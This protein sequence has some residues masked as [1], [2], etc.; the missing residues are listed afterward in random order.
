[1][2]EDKRRASDMAK[3][4]YAKDSQSI[5]VRSLYAYTLF[6]SGDG[7]TAEEMIR[8]LHEY[9]QIAAYTYAM[10]Q[11]N[12]SDTAAALQ[13]LRRIITMEPGSFVAQAANNKLI[14]RGAEYI[15]ENDPQVLKQLLNSQFVVSV[16]PEFNKPQDTVTTK[17]SLSGVEFGYGS[18][19]GMHVIIGNNGKQPLVITDTSFFQGEIYIRVNITGDIEGIRPIEIRKRVTPVAPIQPGG[20]LAIPIQL[21]VEAATLGKILRDF[22]QANLNLSF[23]AYFDPQLDAEGRITS[24]IPIATT[25]ARRLGVILTNELLDKRIESLRSGQAGQKMQ[26][27]KLINGL[28]AE[29]SAAEKYGV[30]Y[31]HKAI[32][33]DSIERAFALALNDDNWQIKLYILDVL[34]I[35]GTSFES[36]KRYSDALLAEQWPIRLLSLYCLSKLPQ[37]EDFE[38]VI[39]WMNQSDEEPLVRELAAL[40]GPRFAVE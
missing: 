17:V 28:I 37:T 11:F 9:N 7:A 2:S 1:M 20:T 36:H 21:N 24:K 19:L 12:K 3:I 10:I 40:E 27:I 30:L 26:T 23:T 31:K 34:R 25:S 29:R 35:A 13:T 14:E 16:V 32:P 22:P 18:D 8:D 38:Q 39:N 15:P 5:D 6:L 33:Q 4:A